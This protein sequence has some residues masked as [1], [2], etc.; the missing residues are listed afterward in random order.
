MKRLTL[1]TKHMQQNLRDDDQNKQ[2][3]PNLTDM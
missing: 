3:A 1:W 2:A